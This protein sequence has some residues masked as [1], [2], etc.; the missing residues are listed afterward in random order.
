MAC[1]ENARRLIRSVLDLLDDSSVNALAFA[2]DLKLAHYIK[3]GQ[4]YT[5][6]VQVRPFLLPAQ[7]SRK[8]MLTLLPFLSPSVQ[9]YGAII[10]TFVSTG[11][12]N[13]QM[14][15]PDVC[16]PHQKVSLPYTSRLGIALTLASSV[17]SSLRII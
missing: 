10:A 14:A 9:I 3:I 17:F 12:L 8:L 16:T 15:L 13:Y 11:I 5:F 7:R 6:A 2:Q 4:R 1:E